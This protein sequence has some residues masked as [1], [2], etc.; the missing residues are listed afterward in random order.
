MSKMTLCITLYNKESFLI[1]LKNKRI[2]ISNIRFNDERIIFDSSF[3]CYLKIKKYYKNIEV[4]K[5]NII[6]KMYSN[7]I[8]T[9]ANL[10]IISLCLSL[11]FIAEN[12]IFYININGVS[13]TLNERISERLKNYGIKKY[14][15]KPSY[16]YLEKI[17]KNIH[18]ELI[19][20]ISVMS[21]VIE[22]V[23]INVNYQKRKKPIFIEKTKTKIYA[24]KDAVIKD[25]NVI[26]G[27][28]LIRR[29]Q[30]VR[31][32]ELL[33]DDVIIRNDKEFYVGTKGIIYGYVYYTYEDIIR[34]E[35]DLFDKIFLVKKEIAN[36]Y[37]EGEY[38]ESEN[39]IRN[40]EKT[41]F[42]FTCVEILNS[43]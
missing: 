42:H 20:E 12:R 1:D 31:K 35:N 41:I 36:S 25:Y 10:F 30:F 40:D 2:N 38:I 15:K 3:I 24:K 6:S 19:D 16:E 28:I 26:S 4:I 34:D 39:I 21:I 33:V 14:I 22:G 29:N 17:N 11:F 37:L 32:G 13:E 43:Y 18:S 7:L 23:Y 5:D 9:I 8:M 27:N